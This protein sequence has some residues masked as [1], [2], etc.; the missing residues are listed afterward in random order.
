MQ[1]QHGINCDPYSS[2]LHS[3]HAFP[4]TNLIQGFS[5][6]PVRREEYN[7]A[8]SRWKTSNY[9]HLRQVETQE[10]YQASLNHGFLA[11]EVPLAIKKELGRAGN[12]EV[13][14]R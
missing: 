7:T 14:H 1:G 13:N 10:V 2:G 11:P 12:G 5:Y 3:M 8:V 4:Q 9:N 6:D